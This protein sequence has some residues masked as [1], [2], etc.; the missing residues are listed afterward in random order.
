MAENEF[1]SFQSVKNKTNYPTP[2]RVLQNKNLVE[3]VKPVLKHT[4]PPPSTSPML[5][6]SVILSATCKHKMICFNI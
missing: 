2:H 1:S 3:S 4:T 6:K 5:P